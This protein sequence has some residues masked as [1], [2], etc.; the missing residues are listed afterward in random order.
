MLVKPCFP[1]QQRNARRDGKHDRLPNLLATAIDGLIR[2]Q[3]PEDQS[4]EDQ[5]AS[6]H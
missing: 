4:Y 1:L 6:V 3:L 2:S 5:H